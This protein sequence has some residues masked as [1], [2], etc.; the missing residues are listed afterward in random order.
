MTKYRLDD[1]ISRQ[2]VVGI[3]LKISDIPVAS[4]HVC[5]GYFSDT[6][7]D[8]SHRDAWVCASVETAA[9]EG[10]VSRSKS[11]FRPRD[12]ITRAEALA[13]MMN[14]SGIFITK[15]VTITYDDQPTSLAYKTGIPQWQIDLIES[16]H[17][18]NIIDAYADGSTPDLAFLPNALAT[19]AEVFAFAAR[20]K[21]VKDTQVF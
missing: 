19:R 13:I 1:T 3:A 20:I 17:V 2:E 11:R 12:S 7:F 8:P 18:N 4:D 15:N 10:L 5:K 9:D 6:T 14:A 16:A 21:E